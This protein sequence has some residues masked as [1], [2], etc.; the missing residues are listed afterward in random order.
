MSGAGSYLE[1]RVEPSR[2]PRSGLARLSPLLSGNGRDLSDEMGMSPAVSNTYGATRHLESNPG[3]EEAVSVADVIA[4]VAAHRSQKRARTL[5]N[6]TPG[7]WS[8]AEPRLLRSELEGSAPPSSH[9]GTASGPAK[10]EEAGK[11]C[12]AALGRGEDS[13]PD[14][15]VSISGE[16]EDG[17]QEEA[18]SILA[19]C[20]HRNTLGVAAV[21]EYLEFDRQLRVNTIGH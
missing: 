18:E 7:H 10:T 17:V 20:L 13:I 5:R 12:E 21:S 2:D 6:N 19:V 9:D 16:E 14:A 1:T 3:E 11:L 15:G 8:E 4:E